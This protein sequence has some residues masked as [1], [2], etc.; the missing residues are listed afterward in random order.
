MA[1]SLTINP[2]I[3]IPGADLEWSA[4]R[5][6]GAGGQNV[7]K[8]SSKVEL[9]FFLE[10]SLA[11]CPGVKERLSKIAAKQISNEG[12]L[13]VTSQRFRDQPRNLEDCREK[14]RELILKA[15]FVPRPRKPTKPSRSA[16][17]ERLQEKRLAG[18]KK[19]G[20]RKGTFGDD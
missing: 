3:T 17:E 11:L 8:V 15:I 2:Y 20:R 14:L 5:A 10:Q 18:S 13:I 9:R 6:S 4:A 12:Q 19:Q 16:R 1:D 7:N